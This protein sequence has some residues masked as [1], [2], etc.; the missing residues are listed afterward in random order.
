MGRKRLPEEQKKVNIKLT[1]KTD[2]VKIL[3]EKDVNISK[4]FE[5][6]VKNY[7]NK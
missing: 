1:V 3:K 4:L 6:F 5:E 2:F 7:L